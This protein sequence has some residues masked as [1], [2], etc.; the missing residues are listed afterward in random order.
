MSSF[1]RVISWLFMP[2]TM[3][4]LALVVVLYTPTHLDFLTFNNS[5]YFLDN[6]VKLFFFNS[7]SLFGWLFPVI[8][9]VIMKF[10]KQVDSVELDNQKQRSLPL[11]MS[12]VYAVFLIIL[13]YKFN[14]QITLSSHLFGLAYAGVFVAVIF[15]II[16]YKFKISLHAGGVGILLG[17]LFS[18]YLEQSLLVFWPFVFMLHYWWIN[19][20]FTNWI[21]ET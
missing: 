4:L 11:I 16:N 1:F 8:S 6:S 20:C 9:I 5:L 14:T 12:G 19:N 15:L 3:P 10:T 21:K 2:L 13:L 18:Y 7:F 17:F